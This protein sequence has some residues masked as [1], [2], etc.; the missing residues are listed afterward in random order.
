MTYLLPPHPASILRLL[1]LTMIIARI[2]AQQFT[3]RALTQN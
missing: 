3:N 2:A 1:N